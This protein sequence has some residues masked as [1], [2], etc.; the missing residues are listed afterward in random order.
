MEV[1][2]SKKCKKVESFHQLLQI[3]F[4]IFVFVV[5]P[6]YV[7]NTCLVTAFQF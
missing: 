1:R 2:V 5:G 6:G 4:V 3:I 7:A